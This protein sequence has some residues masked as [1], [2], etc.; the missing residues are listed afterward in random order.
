MDRV[1]IVGGGII[2]LAVAEELTRRGAH[3]EIFEKGPAVGREASG[4]AAGILS[5]HGEAKGPGPFLDL[6]LAGFQLIPEMVIRLESISG[7]D[8]CYRASGML[9]VSMTDED[10]KDLEQQ[11]F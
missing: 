7:V 5:P 11:L 6:L 10:E 3:P 8:L 2:G 9:A 1:G 4:A